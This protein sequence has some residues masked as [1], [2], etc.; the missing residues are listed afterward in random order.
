LLCIGK[1]KWSSDNEEQDV[2]KEEDVGEDKEG[3]EEDTEDD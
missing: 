2:E 1:S 3:N